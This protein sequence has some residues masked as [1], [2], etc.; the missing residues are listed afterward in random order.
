MKTTPD[1]KRQKALEEQQRQRER[2]RRELMEKRVE[3]E[4]E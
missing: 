4:K 1:R 3:E 2:E